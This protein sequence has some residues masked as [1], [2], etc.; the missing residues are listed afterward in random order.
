MDIKNLDWMTGGPWYNTYICKKLYGKLFEGFI[1]KERNDRYH[2]MCSIDVYE[3]EHQSSICDDGS[4]GGGCPLQKIQ[5]QK[6]YNRSVQPYILL[7]VG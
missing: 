1:I 6:H 2:I 5:Q 7:V 3:K 4:S